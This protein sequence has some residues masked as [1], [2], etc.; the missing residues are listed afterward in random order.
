MNAGDTPTPSRSLRRKISMPPNESGPGVTSSRTATT[1]TAADQT[2]DH[3]QG[4][5]AEFVEQ[6]RHRRH[7]ALR[8]EPLEHR[9]TSSGLSS[10]DPHRYRRAPSTHAELD[11]WAAALEHLAG[12]GYDVRFAVPPDVI[13]RLAGVA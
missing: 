5:A 10:R 7:G 8:C 13:V 11:A 1:K 2:N 3:R 12:H 6:L 9:P 4:S